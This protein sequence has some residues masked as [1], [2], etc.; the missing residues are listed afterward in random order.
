[1]QSIYHDSSDSCHT[2][3]VQ[4]YFCCLW[5]LWVVGTF[6]SLSI[7][8]QIPG[9][10]PLF[11]KALACFPALALQSIS[12][13]KMQC[14]YNMRISGV[15]CKS[16]HLC[17]VIN[18][19]CDMKLHSKSF[20]VRSKILKAYELDDPEKYTNARAGFFHIVLRRIFSLNP[21]HFGGIVQSQTWFTLKYPVEK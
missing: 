3:S 21:F 2:V 13:S 16:L 1:M 5:N 14:T 7:S 15:I 6:F 20:I 19:A 9:L 17:C 10:S 12:I 4:L 18:C 11:L 8:F